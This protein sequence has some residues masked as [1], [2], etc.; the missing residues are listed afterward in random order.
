MF[1]VIL[2]A[3]ITAFIIQNGLTEKQYVVTYSKSDYFFSYHSTCA[4]MTWTASSYTGEITKAYADKS[5]CYFTPNVLESCL[6]NSCVELNYNWTCSMSDEFYCNRYSQCLYDECDCEQ[7]SGHSIFQCADGVGC[8]D[9]GQ[10]C[11]GRPDCLDSSDERLCDGNVIVKCRDFNNMTIS[12]FSYCQRSK[13]LEF[14]SFI[15]NECDLKNI[16][17]DKNEEG[18]YEVISDYINACIESLYSRLDNFYDNPETE[19]WDFVGWCKDLCS[20]I[21][22]NICERIYTSYSEELGYFPF[23]CSDNVSDLYSYRLISFDA[24][25][26]EMLD[27]PDGLD[28]K[29]CTGRFYCEDTGDNL[30][31]ISEHL[32]CDNFRDCTNGKDECSNCSA[33][34]IT[35][36][37]FLIS[38]IIIR[39]LV[40]VGCGLVLLC[41][42]CVIYEKLTQGSTGRAEE[43][44]VKVDK[45][46]LIQLC[47]YDILM[48]IYLGALFVTTMVYYNNYCVHDFDWRSSWICKSLGVIFAMSSHGSLFTICLIC[49]T[50]CYKCV[51]GFSEGVSLKT[52]Y[53][54]S[55]ILAVINLAIAIV[56]V[57]PNSQ[58]QEIFRSKIKLSSENPF[59]SHDYYNT[60]HINRIYE[61]YYG[62]EEAKGTS[63]YDMLNDLKSITTK[64]SI[65]DVDELSYYSYSP[66]CVHDLFGTQKSLV[67]YKF[68]YITII[69]IMLCVVSVCYIMILR[70]FLKSQNAVRGIQQNQQPNQQNN[71]SLKIKVKVCLV[72]GTKLITW[73][74]VMGVM[75]FFSFSK[76]YAADVWYDI[77]A[78]ILIPINSLLNPVFNSDKINILL[79]KVITKIRRSRVEQRVERNK[80]MEQGEEID[81]RAMGRSGP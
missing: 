29:Y 32:V 56:P 13:N 24:V 66:I 20:N 75:M 40:V 21:S 57:I 59:I 47:I 61:E 28:E 42:S 77:T 6:D 23:E 43:L 45:L 51:H 52:V 67:I 58:I 54:A 12:A 50:R 18:K 48:S 41:N 73:I 14:F 63:L 64:P 22:E 74:F 55:S 31:W 11:D 25:C 19:K 79:M 34:F 69:S 39:C 78:L 49:L 65:F 1:L 15:E 8:V 33:S 44:Y 26:N 72:I 36:D 27:C 37:N 46:L 16:E 4:A 53:I 3:V 2:S 10:V 9:M 5:L 71:D 68:G 76:K 80:G 81:M 60:S 38:N 30:E 70:Q 17:C 7:L 35:S 62:Q